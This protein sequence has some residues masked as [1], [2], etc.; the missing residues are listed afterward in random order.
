MSNKKS[1]DRVTHESHGRI[2]GTGD[3]GGTIHKTQIHK[4]DNTYT[5]YGSSREHSDKSAGE[6]YSSGKKDK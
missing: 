2:P 4:G 3:L 1:P 5:G 6:K